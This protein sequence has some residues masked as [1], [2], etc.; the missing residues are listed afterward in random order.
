[1]IDLVRI[2][3]QNPSS[4]TAGRFFNLSPSSMDRPDFFSISRL[5]RIRTLL[6]RLQVL[7]ER[8][9]GYLLNLVV[10]GQ[11]LVLAALVLLLPL[12]AE[13]RAIRKESHARFLLPKVFFYFAALGFGFFFIELALVKKLSFFLESSTLA[14]GTVLAGVLVFSG[15]GSWQ[16]QAFGNAPRRGLRGGLIVIAVSLLFFLFGLD[17]LMRAG[18]GLPLPVRML[19][20]VLVM[21]PISLALGRPF[22]LATSALAGVSDSLIPW[23]WAING[24]FSVLATPLAN[25]LS[26]T[27]G[28]DVV[29]ICALVLYLSTALSFPQGNRATISPTIPREPAGSS[30]R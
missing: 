1:M 13:R 25:I 5:T 20:A 15:L 12:G 2:F 27:T 18:I 28:W 17:P 8:E 22:A 9:I 14:F 6:A 16:A 23:A 26:A 4:T 7:P 19:L 10:L 21:A 30:A 29:F 11:A 24:A 3:G